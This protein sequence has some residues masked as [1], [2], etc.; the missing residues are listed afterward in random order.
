LPPGV[1]AL[2]AGESVELGTVARIAS[3]Q[4]VSPASARDRA[5]VDA[6]FAAS[7]RAD[8]AL[9]T[10]VVLAERS[11]LARTLLE[12]LRDEARAL[13]PP[14]SE[15]SKVVLDARWPELARPSSVITTHALVQ[16]KTPADDAPAHALALEL[17]AALK[18]AKNADEFS[19]RA[20]AFPKGALEITVEQLPPV[21]SDGR[22]WDPNEHP[23]KQ[24]AGSLDRDFTRA[25]HTLTE[26]GAQTGVVKS[27]FG[28]HVIE[29][30]R[31]IPALELPADELA[32][33][34]ADDV[35]ARRAKQSLEALSARLHAATPVEVERAVEELTASV[36]VTP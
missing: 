8:P 7:A 35:Y 31:L 28:Y 34:I 15:E 19:T 14:T 22:M 6:L 12:R 27:A 5:V 2:V 30:D 1:A 21:T 33:K 11:S 4:R 3:A 32:Q 29:L 24:I 10:E 23:P 16:V 26:V 18:D 36:P 17:A 25:A 20:R 9:R 13:G